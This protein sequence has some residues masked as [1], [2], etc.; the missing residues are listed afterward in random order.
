MKWGILRDEM[1]QM[2]SHF[3]WYETR[4]CLFLCSHLFATKK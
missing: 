2:T 1:A 4:S 3:R